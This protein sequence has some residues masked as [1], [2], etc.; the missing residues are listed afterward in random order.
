MP[1][2]ELQVARALN[3]RMRHHDI[4]S[5]LRTYRRDLASFPV[6]PPSSDHRSLQLT[7]R[8]F[9]VRK[10]ALSH[11]AKCVELGIAGLR[12]DTIDHA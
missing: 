3:N 1:E 8:L 4:P 12:S 10:L 6:P 9:R 7:V 5:E 11:R 2:V